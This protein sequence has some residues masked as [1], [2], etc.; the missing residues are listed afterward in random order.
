[1]RAWNVRV[2]RRAM[3][4]SVL[5][6]AAV[7]SSFFLAAQPA[8]QELHAGAV[9]ERRLAGGETH[10]F[11]IEAIP[12]AR[13][14]IT[15]EQRGIDLVIDVL[16]PDGTTLLAVDGIVDGPETLLLPAEAAGP[17]ELRVRSPNPG[18]APGDYS[19]R[20]E[21]LGASTSRERIEAER[22]MTEAAARF[23]EGT[24][25]SLR[26][27]V[28]RY[29][30]ALALWS[31]SGDREREARCALALGDLH[32]ALGQPR[33]A[34]ALYQRALDLF[35]ELDDEPGQA[36]AWSNLGA[37]RTA[38]GDFA[39]GVEAQHRA[40]ELERS[41][42]R[43]Y[44]E[45]KI[46]NHL[47][48]AFHSQG[49]LRQALGFYNQALVVFDRVG[50]HGLWRGKVLHNLAAVHMELGEAEEA[51]ES[52]RQILALQRHLGDPR[53]EAQTF[54]SLGVLYNNLGEFG[55]ALEAYAPA[56]AGFR[57]AGDRMRE[58]AVLHNLGVAFHGLGD[59]QRALVHL[60]Q[61]LSLRR[62]VG[63]RRGEVATEVSLGHVRLA[64]GETAP[65]LDSGQRAARLASESSDRNGEMLARL[66]LGQIHTAAG[67]PEAALA[68]LAKA[69]DLARQWEDRRDEATILQLTGQAYLALEQAD[70]AT[71]ALEAAVDLARAVKTPARIVGALTALA[72]AERLR[73][74]LPEARSRLEEALGRIETV[75][76]RETD[77]ILRAS[78]L[79]AR[80][81][82]FELAID[83]LMELDR[84]EPGQGHAREAL[85]VSE[86]ARA[87]SLLDLLQGAGAEVREGVDPELRARERAL[88]LRLNGKVG[89]QAGLLR[90][91]ATEES[92]RA[93]EAEILS[94]L[95]DLTQ[96][97]AEIRRQS[98]RYA[99]LTEPPLATST[100]IQGLLDGES[101]LL[102]YSLG[103]ERSFLWAVDQS[104][105]TGF[106]LPPRVRIEALAREVHSRSSVL[107]PGDEGPEEAASAL[108]RMLLG[109]VAARLAGKRLII[110]AD[111][112]LH[113]VP[114][115]M[116]PDPGASGEKISVP[117]LAGHEV[118][119][120][121]SASTVALQRRLVR[122]EPAPEAV[123]VLADPVFDP[124]D[125]RVAGPA[126]GSSPTAASLS[127]ARVPSG[128][129][130]FLRLPWTRREAQAISAVAPAGRSLLALDFRASRQTALSPELSRYRIIHF[131]THG[132][133]DSQTPALSGLMLSR[134]GEGGAPVEGFLG[135]GDVY[136]LRLGADLVVLS[137]CETALGK[138][139]R[140]EGLVGL[141]QG[142]LYS[143]AKQVVASLWRVEDRATAELMSRFY[144]GLLLEGRSPAAALREAQLAIRSDKRWR[145]PYYWSGF[146][147]QGDWQPSS[148]VP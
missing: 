124:V 45:G 146:V 48:L 6:A 51:R 79:A 89:F 7:P 17:F 66:L 27:G 110:A 12:G 106:E 93:A 64:L 113:Y 24:A 37:S 94:V 119:H 52:H 129:S 15:A 14:L 92:R 134:V 122:P 3:A 136:N 63:D 36:A 28:G 49:E 138:E 30:E 100:E 22:L 143:G 142:F 38:L 115:A 54:N 84:R 46:L 71:E 144:R 103:E 50:E 139:V 59:Y 26:L 147:L 70:P 47:G 123:A 72:R 60:E 8:R 85:E 1:M 78:Y 145:S 21:E 10:S 19:L 140:G 109:P 91:S 31:S 18:V 32:T 118:V 105:V 148:H 95:A 114:F 97:E 96:I 87:R 133:V 132:V 120:V 23:L 111:G 33:Q 77:P 98:P 58:A 35:V 135:L 76:A 108:S 20:V 131:A 55:Q 62:E 80:Y 41:L 65:A 11:S 61:A 40:L 67:E 101:L 34:L 25:D 4:V 90:R 107:A 2:L 121:P 13:L 69:R 102:Q 117:L 73:G 128:A 127:T 57:R 39:G 141:T 86:R 125:P 42:G 88:L 9:L 5:L 74:R 104:S 53:G 83:L 130:S 137:G 99:A 56:L 68:E 43:L 16:R 116:L 81:S 75:R 82:A 44:Q 126:G 29:E 112:A